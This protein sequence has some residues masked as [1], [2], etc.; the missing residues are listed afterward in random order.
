MVWVFT[1]WR[2]AN[3]T[4]QPVFKKFFLMYFLLINIFFNESLFFRCFSSSTFPIQMDKWTNILELLSRREPIKHLPAPL[5]VVL[6]SR[7][8]HHNV[9][10]CSFL[11][12]FPGVLVFLCKILRSWQQFLIR[13]WFFA[14]K[15]CALN[16]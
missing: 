13:F 15:D 10:G 6:A 12:F 2:S 7:D 11:I 16:L 3:A 1:P 14:V 5:P 9:L 4:K 8:N